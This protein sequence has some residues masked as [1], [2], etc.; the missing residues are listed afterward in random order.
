MN[1]PKEVN[2]QASSLANSSVKT[3]KKQPAPRIDEKKTLSSKV[4]RPEPPVKKSVSGSEASRR[5]KHS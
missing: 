5:S 2:M 1:L 3:A 4:Y